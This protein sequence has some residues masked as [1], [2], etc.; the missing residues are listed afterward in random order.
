MIQSLNDVIAQAISRHDIWRGMNNR[1]IVSLDS[2]RDGYWHR[3]SSDVVDVHGGSRLIDFGILNTPIVTISTA[4]AAISLQN[5]KC[6]RKAD[7][8]RLGPFCELLT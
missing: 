4:I 8:G 6:I 5:D 7:Q 3:C 1:W 2:G